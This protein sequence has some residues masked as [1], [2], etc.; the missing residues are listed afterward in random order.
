MIVAIWLFLNILVAISP[1]IVIIIAR[2]FHNLKL[3]WGDVLGDG[4]LYFFT[5]VLA[6]GL[7]SDAA[8]VTYTQGVCTHHADIARG[9]TCLSVDYLVMIVLGGAMVAAMTLVAY[10]LTL[11]RR[12]SFQPGNGGAAAITSLWFAVIGVTLTLFVRMRIN[13][14]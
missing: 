12:Y 9:A 10:A 14:W 1:I 13:L 11:V 4:F 8:K 7:I 6:A 5:V 3:T 2:R